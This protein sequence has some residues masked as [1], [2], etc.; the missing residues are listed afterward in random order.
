[1]SVKKC[2]LNDNMF[3]FYDKEAFLSWEI[4]LCTEEGSQG[5]RISPIQASNT[6][7]SPLER[8]AKVPRHL[9]KSEK[10][11]NR[12]QRRVSR[13]N[14]LAKALRQARVEINTAGHVGINAWGQTDLYSLVV[15]PTSKPTGWTKNPPYSASAECQLAETIK[16]RGCPIFPSKT[17]PRLLLARWRSSL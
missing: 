3:I 17:T 16:L 14:I 5:K 13:L 12:A 15:T 10:A 11:L 6:E 9:S 1:M 2:C 8:K 4:V 7:I